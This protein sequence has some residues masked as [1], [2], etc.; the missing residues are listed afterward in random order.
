M[1]RGDGSLQLYPGNGPGGLTTPTRLASGA[2]R[3]DWLQGV[4]D[5][6]GDGHADLIARERRSGT[7]WLLPG[8][9]SGLGPRRYLAS[10]FSGYDL[11]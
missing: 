7:L 5:A 6:D 4:G 11:G 1:R 9:G 2:K 8:D 10:G 3:Y